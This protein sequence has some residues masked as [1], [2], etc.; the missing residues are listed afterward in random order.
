MTKRID[1]VKDFDGWHAQMM[2]Q[3][4][5]MFWLVIIVITL[6]IAE[7]IW[8]GEYRAL[9]GLV[10]SWMICIGARYVIALKDRGFFDA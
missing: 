6:V 9:P 2:R 8:L 7:V 10:T 3:I 1:P 5:V 4:K